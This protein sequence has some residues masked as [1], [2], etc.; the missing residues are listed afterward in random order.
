MTGTK[1]QITRTK[2]KHYKKQSQIIELY[3]FGAWNLDLGALALE[4]GF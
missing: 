1:K 3:L 4:L 2:R